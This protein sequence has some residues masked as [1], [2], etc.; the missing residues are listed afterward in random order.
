MS[1]D[2]NNDG[3]VPMI[4]SEVDALPPLDKMMFLVDDIKREIS[5]GQYKSLVD[6]LVE[7]RKS[8]VET[9][10]LVANKCKLFDLMGMILCQSATHGRGSYHGPLRPYEAINIVTTFANLYQN[11]DSMTADTEGSRQSK[12]NFIINELQTNHSDNLI[13]STTTYRSI[14]QILNYSHLKKALDIVESLEFGNDIGDE[15]ADD[16][17]TEHHPH[18]F[19]I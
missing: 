7:I 15:A 8:Q 6:T 14:L 19:N 10:P 1:S 17:M 12:L 9:Q 4:P 11:I 3:D 13:S 16:H 2:S 18:T 5:D